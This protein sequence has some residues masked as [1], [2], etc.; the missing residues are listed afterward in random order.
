M[1]LFLN[2]RSQGVG[3][4]VVTPYLLTGDGAA[5]PP[6]LSV[7][8]WA[9]VN[10]L[11]ASKSILFA[12]H[13]FN[14]SYQDGA[15]SLELLGRYLALSGPF[16]YIG[17]LWPGDAWIPVVDYPF[18]GDVAID[19]GNRLAAFCNQWCAGAHDLSFA[20]HSLGAR[21]V[22]QAVAS[23]GR[24][25]KLLCLMAG[26]INCDA[27]NAQYARAAANCDRIVALAS[28]CDNVLKIAF[29]IG[30]PFADMLNQDHE[31]FQAAL[32]YNGPPP[33]TV[34][35]PPW[36]IADQ[37]DYGHGDYMPPGD[38]WQWPADFVRRNLYG[39]PLIW[40]TG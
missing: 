30:D 23:L 8:P 6:A 34:V 25:V 38:R 9:Q 11:V 16:L 1:T 28:H 4:P 33:P 32:G 29:T 31:P 2:F 27:L 36:Q 39:Q 24:R 5:A 14:V 3:G 19:C 12:T 26:A 37:Q 22:L 13:G 40:P 10:A 17:I 35:Q 7:V 21:L 15:N 18:E 20:S